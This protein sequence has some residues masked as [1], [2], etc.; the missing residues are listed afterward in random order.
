MRTPLEHP[1][2]VGGN[3]SL[4]NRRPVPMR[5]R[6]QTP[7]VAVRREM[8]GDAAKCLYDKLAPFLRSVEP[9][10][11]YLPPKWEGHGAQTCPHEDW[12]LAFRLNPAP[13]RAITWAPKAKGQ[14]L[15]FASFLRAYNIVL[16]EP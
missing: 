14:R 10:G 5:V 9:W 15:S 11:Y 16:V 6:Y 7:L 8:S 3:V 4:P 13:P 2:A 12:P 1:Q